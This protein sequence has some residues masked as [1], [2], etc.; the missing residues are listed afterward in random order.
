MV[1]DIS[2]FSTEEL[3]AELK[4]RQTEKRERE[5]M[6]KDKKHVCRNCEHMFEAFSSNG[7]FLGFKCKARTYFR[8]CSGEHNYV[9]MPYHTCELFTKKR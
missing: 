1:T 7:L 6:E 8:K 3:K 4:R 2:L 9:V 5:E